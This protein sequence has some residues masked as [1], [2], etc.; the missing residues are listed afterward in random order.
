MLVNL[1]SV[2]AVITEDILYGIDEHLAIYG[3][4]CRP[5]A[6]SVSEFDGNLKHLGRVSSLIDRY[7][8]ECVCVMEHFGKSMPDLANR[9]SLLQRQHDAQKRRLVD[10]RENVRRLLEKERLEVLEFDYYRPRLWVRYVDVT[11]V[12]ISREKIED[13]TKNLNSIFPDIQFIIEE[14]KDSRL[15]FLD[16]NSTSTAMPAQPLQINPAYGTRKSGFLLKKSDGKVKRVWQ[17]RRVCITDTEFCLYHADEAKPPVKLMLLTCQLKFPPGEGPSAVGA[18][19]SNGPTPGAHTAGANADSA[20]APT[21]ASHASQDPKRSFYLVSNNRTYQFQAEDERDFDEWTNVLSN[22]MQAVFN[23]ALNGDESGTK[24]SLEGS[25]G[26]QRNSNSPQ[27]TGGIGGGLYDSQYSHNRFG[28]N[29]MS[30]GSSLTGSE[31]D[32][33][34]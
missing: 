17:R 6:R 18:P 21:T 19:T 11:F 10:T 33:L 29:R 13:F 5:P 31:G 30:Q 4:F 20:D 25:S 26:L 27:T 3:L 22:A 14:E 12:I 1:A 16:S 32:L 15:P 24:I 28:A 9:I 2:N 34:E 23:Q 7:L 8:K